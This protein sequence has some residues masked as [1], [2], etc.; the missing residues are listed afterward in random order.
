METLRYRHLEL[1]QPSRDLFRSVGHPS[2]VPDAIQ[3]EGDANANLVKSPEFRISLGAATHFLPD[4]LSNVDAESASSSRRL[5]GLGS[6][7]V[8]HDAGLTAN[9]SLGAGDRKEHLSPFSAQR[10]ADYR[11]RPP[12][13]DVNAGALPSSSRAAGNRISFAE[14]RR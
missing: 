11:P 2:I 13:T 9:T 3:S 12:R 4:S 14:L 7:S 8:A 10:L 6:R 1:R 5:Y